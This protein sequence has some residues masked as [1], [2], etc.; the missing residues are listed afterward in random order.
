LGLL[1]VIHNFVT[2]FGDYRHNL[3]KKITKYKVTIK[4]VKESKRCFIR[5]EKFDQL[6]PGSL[7]FKF[8]FDIKYILNE[9]F[10][11]KQKISVSVLNNYVF[12]KRA[13]EL[14]RVFNDL[15]PMEIRIPNKR[16]IARF[17]P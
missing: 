7:E 17:F 3:Y 5:I 10:G 12:L 4:S 6:K 8:D 13:S 14:Q 2:L 9:I 15:E 1:P 16:F 11:V